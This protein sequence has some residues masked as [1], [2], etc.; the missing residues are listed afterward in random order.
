MRYAVKVGDRVLAVDSSLGE[1]MWPVSTVEGVISAVTA[2]LPGQQITFRF[3]RP[4][5]NMDRRRVELSAQAVTEDTASAT[6]SGSVAGVPEEVLLK[7]C[8]EILKRYATD[9]RKT[10]KFVNK[11]AVRGMVADKVLDAL[12]TAQ[13]KVDRATL[14]MLM[15]AYLASGKPEKAISTF[16]A[17]VGLDSKLLGAVDDVDSSDDVAPSGLKKNIDALDIYTASSLLKAHAMK[18][19]LLSVKRVWAA[20]VKDSSSVVAAATDATAAAKSLPEKLS[21]VVPDACFY[22]IAMAAAVDAASPKGDQLKGVEFALKIFESMEHPK[23]THGTAPRRDVI[24]YN[25][26]IDILTKRGR[27]EEALNLLDQMKRDGVRPD[28][29]SYAT[30]VEAV[31]SASDDDLEELLYDMREQGVV[32][33]VVVYNLII[34]SFCEQRRLA[35]AKRMVNEMEAA[36]LSPDSRSYGLLMKGLI[37]VGKP[38]AAL[39]LF[40]SA[41]SDQK[42]VAL[43][44]NHHLYTTAITAAA[45][46]GDSQRALELLSRMN[47]IGVKPTVKTMTALMGACMSA[48]QANLAVDIYNRIP[49]P[50]GFAMAKGVRAL[51][52]SGDGEAALAML[53]SAEENMS[54]KQIMSVQQNIIEAALRGGDYELARKAVLELLRRGHIPSTAIYQSMFDILQL[55]PSS[56][57]DVQTLSVDEEEK[58]KFKFLLFVLDSTS[59]RNLPC[60]GPLYSAILSYAI[61]LGALPKKIAALLVSARNANDGIEGKNVIMDARQAGEKAVTS[62]EELYV[63]YD[64]LK[65]KIVGP[66]VLPRLTLRVGRRDLPK[67]LRAENGLSFT[68]NNKIRR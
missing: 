18:N 10:D 67:I 25:T 64:D 66:E 24:S 47:A 48:G 1:K 12:E 37:D 15:S 41:C 22:N 44:E 53:R 5:E 13:V 43:T 39:T 27:Y 28:K 11:Y 62:W 9:A 56:R 49:E 7:R 57:K 68:T 45:A 38:G 59:N 61:R 21:T 14:S 2:R 36:G 55:F 40:E 65:G 58:E 52:L 26:A 16:E 3:E 33:D 42:T 6:T 60:D 29:F 50:D 4:L 35:P 54:G 20:V 19:D 32:V 30:L 34:K 31:V 46:V 8:R 23:A 51:S 17:V 63:M